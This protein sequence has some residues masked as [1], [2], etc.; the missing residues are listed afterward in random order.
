MLETEGYKHTQHAVAYLFIFQSNNG[1]ANAPLFYMT[2]ILRVLFDF[3][4]VLI[5]TIL[6][7]FSIAVLFCQQ[8][9]RTRCDTVS[10]RSYQRFEVAYFLHLQR[11][12]VQDETE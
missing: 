8:S 2:R 3:L 11:I 10:T 4:R 6:T 7:K 9:N 1:Y 5:D 12:K